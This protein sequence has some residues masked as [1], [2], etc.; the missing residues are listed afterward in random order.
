M[1]S[2]RVAVTFFA[3]NVCTAGI[4]ISNQ[5]ANSKAA[6]TTITVQNIF[7]A[8]FTIYKYNKIIAYI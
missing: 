1:F 6:T 4:W 5:M 3:T 2:S 8:F 7:S